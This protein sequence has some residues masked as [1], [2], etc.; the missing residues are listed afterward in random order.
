MDK[1]AGKQNSESARRPEPELSVPR[2]RLIQRF[3]LIESNYDP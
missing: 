1:G 3:M 2:R